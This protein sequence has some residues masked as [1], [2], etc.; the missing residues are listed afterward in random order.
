VNYFIDYLLNHFTGIGIDDTFVML[1]GWRR[2]KA[3]MPVAERMGLMM[4]EAAVSITITSVTDF[5]SFLIG[6]I[7]PFRSVRIFCTYSV[8]AVCFTFLWHITFFAA[9]MAISGYR[10]RKNLH[11]IFGCRVQPMSV[12]IKGE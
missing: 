3:K 7:S 4:S 2:T 12:A 11:S 6:I 1:A 5:I 8:F 10:E 9:C